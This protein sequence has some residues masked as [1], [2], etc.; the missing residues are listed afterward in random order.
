V[1]ICCAAFATV[2]PSRG[3]S[4][5]HQILPT[6]VRTRGGKPREGV[7]KHTDVLIVG[8]VLIPEEHHDVVVKRLLDL[9]E[10]RRVDRR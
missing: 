6:L 10:S 2:S 5:R 7:T 9:A 8:E 4:R 1:W 3:V